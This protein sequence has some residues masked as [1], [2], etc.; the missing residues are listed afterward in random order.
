MNEVSALDY[1][2]TDIL[3]EIDGLEFDILENIS[4]EDFEEYGIDQTEQLLT[5]DTEELRSYSMDY[6][7]FHFA[8]SAEIGEYEGD[9]ALGISTES[10]DRLQAES[11]QKLVDEIS[12]GYNTGI[13]TLG[14]G[15]YILELEEF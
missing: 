1:L 10:T 13:R 9:L 6:E 4:R 5:E 3:P 15:E 12:D 11:V 2:E 14:H 8:M 7:N